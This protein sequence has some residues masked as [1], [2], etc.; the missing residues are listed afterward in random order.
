MLIQ[1][2]ASVKMTIQVKDA[3]SGKKRVVVENPFL[4]SL[5]TMNVKMSQTN[6]MHSTKVRGHSKLCHNH[7][8]GNGQWTQELEMAFKT[9]LVTPWAMGN[10][11]EG[12]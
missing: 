6:A 12:L 7:T 2:L 8:M 1:V 9:A 10:G 11:H 3:P 5:Q 4:I